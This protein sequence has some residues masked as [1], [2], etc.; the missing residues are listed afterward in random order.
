MLIRCFKPGTN[1][2]TY[3]TYAYLVG[4]LIVRS[5]ERSQRIY[6]AMLCRGFSG[7]FP[8]VSHFRLG[9]GDVVFGL[10]MAAVTVM[11]AIV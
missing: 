4:M 11:L 3:R 8:V 5:Y 1:M 7:R 2:H 9:K 10:S 6:Q